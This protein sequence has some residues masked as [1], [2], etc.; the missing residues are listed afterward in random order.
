VF[1]GTF[2]DPDWFTIAP[3]T[4]RQIFIETARHDTYLYPGIPTFS[5]HSLAPDGSLRE[6]ETFAEPRLA[7][8]R[9]PSSDE[10][11]G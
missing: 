5:A 1:G 2:D 11:L 9:K 7:G 4:A 10:E 3:E 8:H 6:A